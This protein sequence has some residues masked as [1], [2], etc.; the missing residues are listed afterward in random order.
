MPKADTQN[1]FMEINRRSSS[2]GPSS[3]AERAAFDQTANPEEANFVSDLSREAGEFPEVRS[4]VVDAFKARIRVGGYPTRDTLAALASLI[5]F[6]ILP[7]H[8][9]DS[10]FKDQ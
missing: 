5:G 7:G 9:S 1:G 3:P 6:M 2:S 4:E 8:G 10:S